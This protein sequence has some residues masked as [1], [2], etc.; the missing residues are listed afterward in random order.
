MRSENIIGEK[1]GYS[2]SINLFSAK[3]WDNQKKGNHND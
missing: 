1:T 3:Q 2:H